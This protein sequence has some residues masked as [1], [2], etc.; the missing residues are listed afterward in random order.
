MYT[1]TINLNLIPQGV[2]PVIHVNQYE[3]QNTAFTFKLYKGTEVF[4]VPS[5][6]AVLMNGLKPDGNVFSYA[7]SSVSGQT[8]TFRCEQQMVP[9]AGTVVCELRIRT[10]AE[11]IGTCN[12]LLE[13]EESPVHDDS[14][15]SE[16]TIPLIEQAIDIAANLAEYIE[17][18]LNAAETATDAAETATTAAGEAYVYNSNVQQMYN[19]LETVKANA[20]AAAQAANTAAQAATAAAETLE[21]LSATATTLTPGSAATASYDSQTGVITFGIP[22]GA[23]GERGESGIQTQISGLFA[24]SVDA[25]GNLWAHC[26][27]DELTAANFRYDSDT[28]NL[29]YVIPEEEEGNNG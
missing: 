14:V 17:T 27:N 23:K 8:V 11:I 4:N 29:Y 7:S 6:A 9:V 16:T 3:N 2:P 5:N 26:N 28:G 22:Q 24:L 13:V 21:D 18:T 25:D 19:S 15:I 12:F 20:N 10:T 1:Q